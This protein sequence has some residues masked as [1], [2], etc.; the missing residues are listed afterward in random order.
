VL[1]P[2]T[3]DLSPVRPKPACNA[4]SEQNHGVSLPHSRECVGLTRLDRDALLSR[5]EIQP[6]RFQ[7]DRHDMRSFGQRTLVA[8]TDP[9]CPSAFAIFGARL[10]TRLPE[11]ALAVDET[12]LVDVELPLPAVSHPEKMMTPSASMIRP[13]LKQLIFFMS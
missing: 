10:I 4:R 5:R 12:E 6:V 8:L 11:L 3:W 13:Q 7:N 9:K 2:R 1:R